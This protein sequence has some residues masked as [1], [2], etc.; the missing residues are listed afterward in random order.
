[1]IFYYVILARAIPKCCLRISFETYYQTFYNF[2]SVGLLTSKK[3]SVFIVRLIF[4]MQKR[5][6]IV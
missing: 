4:E 6:N 1:M 3:F 5:W 2:S